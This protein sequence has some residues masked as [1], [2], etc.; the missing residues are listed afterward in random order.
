[1][2]H[3]ERSQYR[4]SPFGHPT[5]KVN[6]SFQFIYFFNFDY[7]IVARRSIEMAFCDNL[8]VLE[9]KLSTPLAT[10]RKSVRKFIFQNLRL[11]TSA[12]G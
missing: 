10:Q 3:S 5:Y 7:G 1:M 6:A 9:S 8:C 12:F 2:F 4:F 11:L